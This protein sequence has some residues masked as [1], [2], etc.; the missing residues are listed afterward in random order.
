MGKGRNVSDNFADRNIQRRN[1]KLKEMCPD[2]MPREKMMTKGAGA[3]SNTELIAI[4]L[5]TGRG[6]ANVIDVARE[7]LMSGTG[8]LGGLAETHSRTWR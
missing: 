8:R 1:M 2:E 7:M 6:G 5:R 3:L 4:L